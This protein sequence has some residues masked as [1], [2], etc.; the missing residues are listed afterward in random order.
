MNISLIIT[1]SVYIVLILSLVIGF[2]I[3]LKRGL[4]KSSIRFG[5]FILC[6][7]IAGLITVP[8][9]KAILNAD[10]SN[11]GIVINGKVASSITEVVKGLTLSNEKIAEAVNAMPSVMTLIESLPAIIMNIVVFFVLVLV[12]IFI[13][14]IIYVIIAKTAL[15]QSKI[16]R[17]AKKQKK[18][19]EKTSK[20]QLI[21][22]E[23]QQ[24]PIPKKKKYRWW[25]ACVGLVNG[26][27]LIF[28]LL[29]PITSI[30]STF[31]DIT[32][33]E[34]VSAESEILTET[35]SDIIRYYVGSDI[36]SYANAYSDSVAG[37]ILTLGGLDDVI[38]DSIASTKVNNEKVAIRSDIK[39]F[40]KIYDKT[41][42]LIDEIGTLDSYS[43]I[44]FEK[45]DEIFNITFNLGVFRAVVGDVVPYALDYFYSTDVFKNLEHNSEIKLVADAVIEEL[46]INPNDFVNV[47]KTQL[48]G[49]IEVGKTACKVG[50]VDDIIGGKTDYR[51]IINSLSKDDY[52]LLNSISENLIPLSATKVIISEGGNIVI[53]SLE[54][55]LSEEINLG[56][57]ETKNVDWNNFK[58]TFTDEAK[59]LLKTFDIIDKYDADKVFADFSILVKKD[60]DANDFGDLVDCVSKTIRYLQTNPLFVGQSINTFNAL[61]DYA[62][63]DDR[64]KEFVDAKVIKTSNLEEEISN[65]KSSVVAL[66]QSGILYH[67]LKEELDVDFVAKQLS[68]KIGDKTT[69]KVILSPLLDSKLAQKTIKFGLKKFNEQVPTLRDALGESVSEIDLTNF[70][71]L[72]AEDKARTIESAESIVEAVCVFGYTNFRDNAFETVFTFNDLDANNIVKS[73]YI[74][75]VLNNLKQISIFE[76]TYY[77]IFDA[78]TT[79]EK[80]SKLMS[81]EVV[82]DSDFSWNTEFEFLDTLLS[83]VKKETDGDSIKKV[84]YPDGQYKEVVI[85]N[86]MI[87]KIFKL[88]LLPLNETKPEETSLNTLVTT[89][90]QSKLFKKALPYILNI[91]NERVE[92][93]VSTLENQIDIA[94]VTIEQLEESQKSDIIAVLENLAKCFDIITKE[95]FKLELLNDDEIVLV[96]NFLNSLKEN[97]F[98]YIDGTPNENCVLTSD[99][100]NIE[101]GGIFSQLYIAMIDYAKSSYEISPTI[102]YGEIEWINFL[103][104]AKK[105]SEISDGNGDILDIISDTESDVNV[106]EA[107]E[108]IGVEKETADKINNVKDSFSNTDSLSA[109][110]YETL[111]DSLGSITTEDTN[112]IIDTVQSSTGKDISDAINTTTLANEQAVSSRIS[113][114][115]TTGLNDENLDESLTDLCN[116]ATYVLS[117]AITNGVVLTYSITGG[118]ETLVNKINEK[119]S[120]EQV[121]TLVKTLFGI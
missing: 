91:V 27:V 90:Y 57:I 23:L 87:S 16:E 50:L 13:S 62:E 45:V 7:I 100:K 56:E 118:Q 60:I 99:G 95:E 53:D 109:E 76:K 111:A 59:L 22:P 75:N 18:L 17:M 92:K 15:K 48:G 24:I 31:S 42:L 29:L 1:L 77:S 20:G 120:N 39:N 5:T 103:K 25:G 110:S 108:I 98:D 73:T 78:L 10:I 41:V 43:K 105:L 33:Q 81:A 40:A 71:Y 116:G 54:K 44:D 30:T 58:S 89:L 107:L 117:H 4:V 2:L 121:R 11:L 97:A 112:K 36:I 72:S 46:K 82:K 52:A 70:T 93:V 85:N 66:Q 68:E 101:N 106:G 94:D 9:S 84:M 38:F 115:M 74:A 26:F 96:G 104:T 51:T 88:S 119:T 35:S 28:L 8:I 79:N 80:Y 55:K 69:T 37:K 47:L 63:T 6:A 86:T 67:A 114:L 14:W 19:A 12:M 61:I 21:K 102:S 32:H 113:M 65:L 64:F 49:V 3:G 83:I 34:T